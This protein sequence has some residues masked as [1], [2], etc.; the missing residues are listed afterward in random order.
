MEEIE[1]MKQSEILDNTLKRCIHDYFPE[2]LGKKCLIRFTE[3]TDELVAAGKLKTNDG[4]IGILIFLHK[5]V[6][7]NHLSIQWFVCH[8]LCHHINLR[9][10]DDVFSKRVPKEVWEAWQKLFKT[11]HAKCEVIPKEVNEK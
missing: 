6:P 5:S 11:G 1:G 7:H 10:P 4:S 2:F 3:I 8:E 9:N